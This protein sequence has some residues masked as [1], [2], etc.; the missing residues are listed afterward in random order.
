MTVA[1]VHPKDGVA[2]GLLCC[3]VAVQ[4]YA[5]PVWPFGPSWAIWPTLPMLTAVAFIGASVMAWRPVWPPLRI[6]IGAYAALVCFCV[7]SVVLVTVAGHGMLLP[8]ASLDFGFPLY[9]MWM[10]LLSGGCFWAASTIHFDERRMRILGGIT[11][12][13]LAW[14]AVTVSLTYQNSVPTRT[15]APQIPVSPG[16]SGP[17]HYYLVNWEG[18]GLGTI[19][20]NHAYAGSLILILTALWMHMLPRDRRG[21]LWAAVL[22]LALVVTFL[23]G[24]R[25]GLAAFLL[26]FALVAIVERSM[27]AFLLLGAVTPLV[28]VGLLAMDVDLSEMMERQRTLFEPPTT[29]TLSARDIIWQSRLEFLNE[30]KARWLI[31][32]GF[33]SASASGDNAHMLFLHVVVEMGVLGLAA[34]GVFFAVLLRMLWIGARP[35]RYLFLATVCLL[36]S[37]MTQETLYPVPAMGFTLPLYLI[38]IAVV[39]RSAQERLPAGTGSVPQLPPVPRVY[40]P[41]SP[42]PLRSPIAAERRSRGPEA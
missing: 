10:M 1:K 34:F 41:L 17:Y 35:P 29:E 39:T 25:A 36:F 42:Y 7:L 21:F 24:S 13:A 20:Y 40:R 12:L 15:F 19:S 4:G 37:S 2:F 8:N 3:C 30:D 32:T 11:L 14:I 18:A 27:K 23:T 28:V 9:Q 22:S 38:A 6:A 31:G 5:L 26:F 33:G 16:V